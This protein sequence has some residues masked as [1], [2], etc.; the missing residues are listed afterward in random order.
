MGGGAEGSTCGRGAGSASESGRRYICPFD[1]RKRT[2]RPESWG[3]V[4]DGTGDESA[5]CTA[6]PAAGCAGWSAPATTFHPESV[7][8]S[9]AAA[10]LPFSH[11]LRVFVGLFV[12]LFIGSL[13]G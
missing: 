1:P 10:R 6:T 13:R 2:T 9:E 5:I 3:A 8:S 4:T 7:A 11:L 12:G